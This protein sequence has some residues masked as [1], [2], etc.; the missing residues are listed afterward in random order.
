MTGE[1]I[2][3]LQ[4]ANLKQEVIIQST[5]SSVLKKIQQNISSLYSCKLMYKIDEHVQDVDARA[6]KEIASFATQVAVDKK[7]L[8]LGRSAF[9]LKRTS[10]VKK[11]KAENLTVFAY[12][13]YNE[14]ADVWWDAYNDPI[15]EINTYV[16]DARIDGLFTEFPATADAFR[17]SCFPSTLSSCFIRIV[18]N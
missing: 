10:V 17:S 16:F 18:R 5:D 7:S 4:C 9:L 2:R 13:F 3:A 14:V 11:L 15:A 1:V 6:V 8:Y 12:L